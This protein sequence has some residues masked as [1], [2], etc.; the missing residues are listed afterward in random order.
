MIFISVTTIL[1]S[2]FLLNQTYSITKKQ[3]NE[4]VETQA[5]MALQFDLA[6]RKYVAHQ[7]RPRMY[8]LLK[9]DEFIPETMSTS[10][11]ARAIFEDVRKEFP[12]YLIKFSSDN[13]R[14]PANQAGPEELEIIEY[15]NKNKKLK[16][17]AGEITIGKNKYLAKF[18]ARRMKGECSQ[19]HGD[20]ADAPAPLLNRYGS[21]AGFHRPIGDVIGLDTVAIPTSKIAAKLWSESIGTLVK[22]GIGLIIFFLVITFAIRYFITNRLSSIAEYFVSAA[23]QPNYSQIEPIAVKGN[24]EISDLTFSFNAL[25]KKLGEFYSSLEAKVKGRTELLEGTNSLLKQEIDERGRA[26]EA[27]RE[28]ERFLKAVI[29]SIQDGINVLDLDLNV[30]RANQTVQ[31]W[32]NHK[33]PLEGKKCYQVYHGRSAPCDVCPTLRALKSGNLE[34]NTIEYEGSDEKIINLEV[35]AYPMLN[36]SGNPVAIV[37]Y[38]RDITQRK[39]AEEII[40]DRSKFQGVLEMAGAVSHELN[41]PMQVVSII[42]EMLMADFKQDHSNYENIKTIKEQTMRMGTITEKLMRVTRYET[43]DYLKGKIIDIDRAVE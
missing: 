13:P 36:D 10:Y 30:V 27:L 16:K 19:C 14:N 3:V 4:A 1:F 7:I 6:I 15:F 24:D 42:S 40:Q 43:K 20:P 32:Y 18:S 25:S 26:E 28:N 31:K 2:A 8:E 37:E 12:D 9:E 35:F 41:Q 23:R 29:D 17:W 5:A 21:T 38:V 22:S 11:V 39:K 34:M 33:L